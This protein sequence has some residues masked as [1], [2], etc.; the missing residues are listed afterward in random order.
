MKETLGTPLFTGIVE[1]VGTVVGLGPLRG[2][3]LAPAARRLAI[4]AGDLLDELGHG[5]SVAVNG[6][7]LTL[8][9]RDGGAA[10]FDVIEE[11]LRRSNLGGLGSGDG[12]NLERSLRGGD[13]L[14]GHFVQ[15][16]VDAIGKLARIDRQGGECRLWIA[17]EADAM[18]FMIPKGSVALDGVSLT[19][20]DVLPDRFCVA[21]IPATLERTTL[22]RRRAGDGVNIETDILARTIVHRLDA[23]AATG[24]SKVSDAALR[25]RLADAGFLP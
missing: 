9:G 20:A 12:V 21:L 5:A 16:H 2:G 7:C 3:A 14:D 4:D 18:R 10:Q 8:V 19:L 17:A 22:G 13:R 15:G 1:A 24:S 25:E 11:T 6:V 23:I